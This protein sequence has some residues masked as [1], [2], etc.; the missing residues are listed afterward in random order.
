M[1]GWLRDGKRDMLREHCFWYARTKGNQPSRWRS[2]AAIDANLP[3]S[4]GVW[5][6]DGFT[7][8]LADEMDVASEDAKDDVSGGHT[9]ETVGVAYFRGV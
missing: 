3:S 5:E 4:P 2:L 6:V 7:V 8:E 1:T 9:K